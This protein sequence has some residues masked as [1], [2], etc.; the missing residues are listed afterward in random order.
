[1]KLVVAYTAL[2]RVNHCTR[3]ITTLKPCG[4]TKK[5]FFFLPVFCKIVRFILAQTLSLGDAIRITTS[6]FSSSHDS[7]CFLQ[8]RGE[9]PWGGG[10]PWQLP[11]RGHSD[12]QNHALQRSLQPFVFILCREACQWL[13]VPS[14]QECAESSSN[15][16]VLG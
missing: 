16:C 15:L 13:S 10:Y 4:A 2:I 5:A 12:V 3:T 9:Y 8:G 7:E 11:R 14:A 6:A 1:M